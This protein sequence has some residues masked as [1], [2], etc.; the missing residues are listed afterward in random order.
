MVSLI[1]ILFITMLMTSPSLL[2]AQPTGQQEQAVPLQILPKDNAGNVDWV[3]SL[4]Q[5]IIKP[6]DSLDP[7]KPSTPVIDLDIVFKVKGDLPDVV[8][9]I[10]LTQSGFHAIT[11]IQ[12]YSLCRQA[13][14]R[15][16]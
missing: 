5:G 9:L 7:K 13:L 4:R 10:T 6:K 1:S 3:K 8:Y 11:V 15:S 12:R 14:T 16:R 2:Y